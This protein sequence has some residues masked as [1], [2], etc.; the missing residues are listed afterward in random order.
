[1]V[2]F[3]SFSSL[4]IRSSEFSIHPLFKLDAG[5]IRDIHIKSDY[6]F[7]LFEDPRDADD[8]VYELNGYELDGRRLLVEHQRGRGTNFS[9][10]LLWSGLPFLFTRSNSE[11]ELGIDFI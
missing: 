11:I 10:C 7:V 5:R 9:T 2:R 1:M 4:R 3:S 8:A 6:G